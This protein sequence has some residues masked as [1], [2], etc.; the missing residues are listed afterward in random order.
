MRK[1][2]DLDEVEEWLAPMD[3]TG[4]WFAV[5][6]LK[7][8]L[9]DRRH[10]DAQITSGEVEEKLILGVLKSMARMEIGER[11]GLRWRAPTP[12]VKAV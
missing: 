6:S 12:W 11:H 2:K 8:K 7:L 9:Q 5:E 3:Y 1:F 10:C 4:F